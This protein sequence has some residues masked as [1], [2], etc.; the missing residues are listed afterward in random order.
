MLREKDWQT[1]ARRCCV[2]VASRVVDIASRKGQRRF[3]AA[4]DNK[5]GIVHFT[6]QF[7]RNR[8]FPFYFLSCRAHVG[9][10]SPSKT[11]S[12]ETC[13]HISQRRCIMQAKLLMLQMHKII[14]FCGSRNSPSAFFSASLLW[15]ENSVPWPNLSNHSRLLHLLLTN[16]MSK[17]IMEYILF[18]CLF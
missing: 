6:C 5:G 1:D 11:S 9:M 14:L 15:L 17:L 8:L 2:N 3:H 18:S 13:D 16:T 12:H 7:H 4:I 10:P